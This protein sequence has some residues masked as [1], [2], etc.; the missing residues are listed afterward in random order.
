MEVERIEKPNVTAS[1]LE[2]Q[3]KSVEKRIRKEVQRKGA[4]M[5]NAQQLSQM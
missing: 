2:L 1:T 5:E 3:Q 4:E